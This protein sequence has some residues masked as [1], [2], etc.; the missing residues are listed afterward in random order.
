MTPAWSGFRS[1]HV[2]GGLAWEL[3]RV[4]IGGRMV[5]TEPQRRAKRYPIMTSLLYRSHSESEWHAGSTVNFSHTGVLF[6]AD[7]PLPRVGGAVDLI[8]TLPLNGMTL[9]PHVRCTGHVVRV[10]DEDLAGGRR[11]VVVEI[12]GYAFESCQ[13]PGRRTSTESDP[14]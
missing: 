11:A 10:I 5:S 7:G 1:S 3:P 2:L 14:T 13:P 12:D 8:V 4:F 9:Q 6:R